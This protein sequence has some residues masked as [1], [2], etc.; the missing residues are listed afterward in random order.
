MKNERGCASAQGFFIKWKEAGV[1]PVAQ[2]TLCSSCSSQPPPSSSLETSKKNKNKRSICRFFL[3]LSFFFEQ[4][5]ALLPLP[6]PFPSF[7]LP[8]LHSCSTS[9]TPCLLS[10]ITLVVLCGL[11][12]GRCDDR[13][14]QET[15]RKGVLQEFVL[16]Y[17]KEMQERWCSREREEKDPVEGGPLYVRGCVQREGKEREG[18]GR[19][20]AS[21]AFFCFFVTVLGVTR[22][23][24]PEGKKEIHSVNES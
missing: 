19:K 12:A 14:E 24:G 9:L 17:K 4:I 16:V 22:R 21:T 15:R 23:V 13:H 18:K 8:V 5:G 3:H 2:Q 10:G 20:E 1:D 6:H 7:S 11:C